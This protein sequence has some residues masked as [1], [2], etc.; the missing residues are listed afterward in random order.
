[1]GNTMWDRIAAAY[2]SV[3]AGEAEK[4][5]IPGGAKVYATSGLVRIDIP[6]GFDLEIHDPPKQ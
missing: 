3:A 4:V 1:M 2:R 5:E 6:A